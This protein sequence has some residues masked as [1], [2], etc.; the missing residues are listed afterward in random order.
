MHDIDDDRRH[1]ND[2]IQCLQHEKKNLL[3]QLQLL[4]NRLIADEPSPTIDIEQTVQLNSTRQLSH[5][6]RRT[7][8]RHLLSV[9][10]SHDDRT[11]ET[12]ELDNDREDNNADSVIHELMMLS[13]DQHDF[14]DLLLRIISKMNSYLTGSMRLVGH[15]DKQRTKPNDLV[16]L[17]ILSR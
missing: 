14:F 5:V 1:L 12:I 11:N 15:R 4:Q 16:S 9:S 13:L 2:E 10:T 7:F 6:Y 8:E 3:I 17:R